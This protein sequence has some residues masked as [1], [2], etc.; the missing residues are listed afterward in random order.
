MNFWG[1]TDA[2]CVRKQ[3]QDTYLM[4][5]LDRNSA[6]CV[7]CDGMGGLA[8]GELASASVIRA[9]EQWFHHEMPSDLAAGGIGN[10]FSGLDVQS[11]KVH[12]SADHL[13]P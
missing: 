12:G 5:Q 9:F 7:V 8:K 11:A 6:I 3:N 2:G 10:V 4:E 1:L 13:L